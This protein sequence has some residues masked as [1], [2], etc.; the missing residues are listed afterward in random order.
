M[1]LLLNHHRPG[2]L[3]PSIPQPLLARSRQPLP[4]PCIESTAPIQSDMAPR[5]RPYV[6]KTKGSQISPESPLRPV[7]P[8]RHT[9]LAHAAAT[10]DLAA[11]LLGCY[12]CGRRRIHCD[13]NGP[14]CGKCR[15][16]GLKCTG[17][18]VEIYVDCH[19]GPVSSVPVPVSVPDP[20]PV[21]LG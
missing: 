3:N 5:R 20:G 9:P 4:S 10:A 7:S 19:V 14:Q 13:R 2:R 1:S 21:S 11:C 16:R 8:P 17:L 15:S 12:Q 6:P 18:G